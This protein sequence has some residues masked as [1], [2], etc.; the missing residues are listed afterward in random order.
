MLGK[1]I[2]QNKEQLLLKCKTG[3]IWSS[4]CWIY[5]YF[6][7]IQIN[8]CQF[9]LRGYR[10]KLNK[11]LQYAHVTLKTKQASEQ[12]IVTL[13]VICQ[14]CSLVMVNLIAQSCAQSK[15]TSSRGHKLKS[16]SYS[17]HDGGNPGTEL[18]RP[19]DRGIFLSN[20]IKG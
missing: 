13:F 2:S 20:Q 8:N 15:G 6:L 3:S 16:I 11:R 10:M 18:H 17:C 9:I 14:A 4:K 12:H 1:K 7:P 19:R 5:H